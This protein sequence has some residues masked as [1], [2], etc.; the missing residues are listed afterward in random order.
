M[1]PEQ[2]SKASQSTMAKFP[3]ATPMQ[4]TSSPLPWVEL[5]S[6]SSSRWPEEESG[7]EASPNYVDHVQFVRELAES[8]VIVRRVSISTAS[9]TVSAAS[10][11]RSS[12]AGSVFSM[13]DSA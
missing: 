2:I 10:S 4:R 6:C 3:W 11:R 1:H 12:W 5:N 9:A 13:S 7:G 8:G